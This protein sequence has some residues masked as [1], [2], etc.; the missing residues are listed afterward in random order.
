MSEPL[1]AQASII[2]T[3][4]ASI[5]LKQPTRLLS[6]LR[7]VFYQGLF[8]FFGFLFVCI[9]AFAQPMGAD[10]DMFTYRVQAN[11]TLIKLAEQYTLDGNNWTI[12]QEINHVED[13]YR[14]PIGKVIKI[15]FSLI[16]VQPSTAHLVHLH[17]Q[18]RLNDAPA[19]L[20]ATIQAG[21]TLST[22]QNS[23]ATLELQDGSSLSLPAET[24]LYFQQI[25]QFVGVPLSDVI[26]VLEKGHI[27]TNA[28]PS[29]Q[30]VGRYEIHTPVSVT[31]V[32]GTKM[33]VSS[34]TDHSRTELLQG[35][36]HIQGANLAPHLLQPQ[37]GAAL[38]S[39]GNL[40]L[41]H[42]LDAPELLHQQ[43][44]QGG[45]QLSF[46]P[47]P[48]AKYYLAVITADEAGHHI[49]GHQQSETPDFVLR[50]LQAGPHYAFI[51]AV[52]ANDFMGLDTVIEYPGRRVL[53]DRSGQPVRTAFGLVVFL[54]DP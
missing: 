8:L 39:Q 44:G 26:F 20:N 2:K 40:Q 43:P 14:L 17:G 31:G 42:L 3:M 52:D 54:D 34:A 10:G 15:P 22:A 12:L 24:Q 1:L 27:E 4:T 53:L 46:A 51:R 36:A 7:P 29:G 48:K 19:A 23:F 49:I 9:S 13:P 25:N 35:V 18:V 38:D 41:A 5:R 33:R 16:P 28:D 45:V 11:D 37:Q 50:P 47:V 30:G 32:R 21:D 6:F